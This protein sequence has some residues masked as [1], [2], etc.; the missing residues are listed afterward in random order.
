[1]SIPA[2]R[3]IV[4]PE[5]SFRHTRLHGV[6]LGGWFSQVDDL[7][8]KDPER[9]PGLH[10]HLRSFLGAADFAQIR[11]WGFNHV[12]LPVDYYNVFDRAT[13]APDETA[14]GLLATNLALA[15]EAGLGVILDL[16]RCPGH[17]FFAGTLHEQPFFSDPACRR[18]ALR[19]WSV[20][21]ERFGGNPLVA[22][23]ILNEPVASTGAIWN[24]VKDEFCTH[25]RRLAPRSTIVV[26]SNRWN[27]PS[28]FAELT[29]VDD[30][31]IL[32]SFHCYAPLLFTHQHAPWMDYPPSRTTRHWPV[33][34]GEDP[35]LPTRVHYEFGRWDSE[36]LRSAFA[37]PLAFREKHGV[38]VACNEFGVYVQAPPA[39]RLRYMGELIGIFREAGFGWSYWNYKNLDFGILSL[40]EA[41]HA[42]LP[43]YAN[44]ERLDRATLA[45]LQAG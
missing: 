35:G 31:N 25:L 36:R 28:E 45:I 17:D 20:L 12:R 41:L 27:I 10:P 15:T 22:L 3:P 42:S 34:F 13:L 1:M 4:S 19:V 8:S 33:D 30:D 39:D 43:Q 7:Y 11:Q 18:D 21:A 44:P 6:N 37:A 29:P 32:Y 23:E 2:A 26:G 24:A 14:L 38:P 16:H 40:G 9:N 5:F